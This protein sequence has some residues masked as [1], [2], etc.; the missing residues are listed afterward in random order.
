[1]IEQKTAAGRRVAPIKREEPWLGDEEIALAALTLAIMLTRGKTHCE[2]VTIRNLLQLVVNN[3]TT[4][5][6]QRELFPY[7]AYNHGAIFNANAGLAEDEF[8]EGEDA[9]D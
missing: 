3:M 6:F 9:E 8:F 7:C 5:D 4:I 1:M 2:I